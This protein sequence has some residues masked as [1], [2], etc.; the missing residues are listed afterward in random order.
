M[1]GTRGAERRPRQ[2][3]EVDR[4]PCQKSPSYRP[5]EKPDPSEPLPFAFLASRFS[6][7]VLLAAFLLLAPP[8]SLLAMAPLLVKDLGGAESVPEAVGLRLADIVYSLA[9]IIALP[10]LDLHLARPGHRILASRLAGG[11]LLILGLA[12]LRLHRATFPLPRSVRHG[13]MLLGTDEAEAPTAARSS[14][15]WPRLFPLPPTTGRPTRFQLRPDCAIRVVALKLEAQDER[16]ARQ[17]GLDLIFAG[18]LSS[19]L[20]TYRLGT[21]EVSLA[22]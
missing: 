2:G 3:A 5:E 8:L 4:R 22:A 21:V 17:L 1:K 15:T 7:S 11:S 14:P 16:S 20:K 12:S 9:R 19:G 18:I 10:V 13:S 6:L